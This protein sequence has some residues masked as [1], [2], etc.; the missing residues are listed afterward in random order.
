[1]QTTTLH[2]ETFP[3][4]NISL[5]LNQIKPISLLNVENSSD[6]DLQHL[7]ITINSDVPFLAPFCHHIEV[8]PAQTIM[9]VPLVDLS[10]NRA[11]LAQLSETEQAQLSVLLKQG[12]EVLAEHRFSL[13]V[14]PLEHFGGFHILPQLIAAYITPNHPYVYHLKRKAIEILQ[15]PF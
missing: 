15:S 9:E 1:M 11:F 3:F 14:Q 7:D 2:L 13:N 8:L 5:H 4:F 10:V 12:S 6:T